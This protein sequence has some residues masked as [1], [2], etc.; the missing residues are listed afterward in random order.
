MRSSGCRQPLL[1]INTRTECPRSAVLCSLESLL[2]GDSVKNSVCPKCSNTY[3]MK[4]SLLHSATLNLSPEASAESKD[5]NLRRVLFCRGNQAGL[6][7]QNRAFSAGHNQEVWR[8]IRPQ[9]LARQDTNNGV[10]LCNY[11]L[12][13]SSR[14]DVLGFPHH[15]SSTILAMSDNPRAKVA[16]ADALT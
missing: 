7:Q 1:L 13:A 3:G 10:G 5:F 8:S 15:H 6:F 14:R 4:T 2:W 16:T 11:P 9:G 12:S